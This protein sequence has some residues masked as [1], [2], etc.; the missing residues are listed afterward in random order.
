MT[1][2]WVISSSFHLI[3]ELHQVK[4]ELKWLTFELYTGHIMPTLGALRAAK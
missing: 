1:S 2:I 4:N 3:F